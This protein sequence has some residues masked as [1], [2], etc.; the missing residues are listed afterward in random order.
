[1]DDSPIEYRVGGRA[2]LVKRAVPGEAKG[3]S[4]LMARGIVVPADHRQRWAEAWGSDWW[5]L[6]VWSPKDGVCLCVL[7]VE[8]GRTRAIPGFRVWHVN[9]LGGFP[10]VEAVEVAL[11]ALADF[12]A[13]DR[14]VLNLSVGLSSGDDEYRGRLAA[15]AGSLG[16]SRSRGPRSYMRTLRIDL[17]AGEEALLADMRPSCRRGI[18]V[19]DKRP[20]EVRP[21][22]DPAMGPRLAELLSETMTRTRGPRMDH[23]WA[24][25]IEYARSF[26]E[27]ARILGM[28]GESEPAD[29]PLAFA[30]GLRQGDHVEYR[31]AA[32]TRFGV[33]APLGYALAWGLILWAKELG[34]EWFD[35]G[36]LPL[37]ASMPPEL[38]GIV[39]FKESF[40]GSAVP[41]REEWSIEAR[42]FLSSVRRKLSRLARR[43]GRIAR[44]R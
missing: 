7:L 27:S 43:A 37:P 6:E 21:I 31:T 41:F 24:K 32:S 25:V 8:V 3:E 12:A 19:V 29:R 22:E 26:P 10:D 30:L 38:E 2:F 17:D 33:R 39:R 9:R 5:P 13:K 1:L 14:R 42:P 36:G 28:F 23:T 40:G 35:F 44:G 11:G 20:I 16:Y 34:A 4:D 15:K 18:R